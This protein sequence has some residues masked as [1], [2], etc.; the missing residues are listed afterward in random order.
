MPVIT[1]EEKIEF[2]T[3]A[4]AV[5]WVTNLRGRSSFMVMCHAFLPT[6]NG[7]GFPGQTALTV[8]RKDFINVI[9]GMGTTLVDD[10]GGKIVLRVDTPCYEGG[11]ASVA[12]Y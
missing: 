4:A 2:T 10:R 7:R 8:S 1:K 3:V 11:R 12:L 6:E 9:K 5:K